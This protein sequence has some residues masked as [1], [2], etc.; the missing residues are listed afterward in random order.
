MSTD[1]D[2]IVDAALGAGPDTAEEG[3]RVLPPPDAPMA[4][5]E[6]F[7]NE[8]YLDHGRRLLIHH[9]G[10]F[11][12]WTGTHFVEAEPASVRA[13]LYAFT[14]D[15]LREDRPSERW[16][17]NRKRVADLLEALAA[18]VHVDGRVEPPAWLGGD[19]PIR[20]LALRNGLLEL[21]TRRLHPHTP[22]F[23]NLTCLPYDYDPD[24][25][26]CVRWFRFL[27][28]LWGEDEES[29]GALQ[30]IFAYILVGGTEQQKLF[31]LVGPKRSGKGTIGRVITGLLGPE[32]VAGPTLA[33][34]TTNFGVSP[35]I[36]KPLAI[37]SDARLSSRADSLVAVERLL[38]IS[39]EDAIT[40]DRK[41]REPWT[42]RLPTRFLILTNE[43]PRFTD[44]SGALASRFIVLV[45]E[46]TFYGSENPRLTEE[47]LEEAP[48]ILN[49]ALEG[50]DRLAAR[51]HFLVPSASEEAVRQLEDLSSPVGAFVRERCRLG[52]ALQV[53]KDLLYAA[54]REWCEAAGSKPSPKSVF[55]RDLRAA[56]PHV[57]EARPREGERRVRV[58]GGIGLDPR[59]PTSLDHPGPASAH[60]ARSGFPVRDGDG[61]KRRSE[62]VVQDGPGSP[63]L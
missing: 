63:R 7:P 26:P 22:E 40:V 46:K 27:E 47:L 23:F 9:R 38:S 17:P 57:R 43:L 11:W 44:S 13:E 16:K 52:A 33:S 54:W 53:E 55:L 41:Y 6:A 31:L 19:G 42:G 3:R 51:G 2:L 45:L 49:W 61:Q 10:S 4:V 1:L 15:A 8:R 60:A 35:L 62:G 48:S 39:G 14:E 18:A 20:V 12:R 32:N 24:A 50:W 30:E 58:L 25:P 28:E 5:V 56:F 21:P 34:L 36:G 29:I 59:Y 37:I